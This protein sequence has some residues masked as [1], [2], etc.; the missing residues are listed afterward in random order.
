MIRI[1][2]GSVL[3]LFA[4]TSAANEY[5]EAPD[6]NRGIRD[7]IADLSGLDPAVRARAACDLRERGDDAAEAIQPLTAML[8]DAAP[9]E[10]MVCNRSWWRGSANDLTSP[11]EQ[12]AAALVAIGSRA[13]DPVLS[14]L[15][16][17]GLGGAAE[18]RLGAGGI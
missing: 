15:Q 10:A 12:A 7:L 1:I 13:F 14:T 3:A 16:S 4:L 5:P 9:V 8:G 18:R 2:V 11:G 6:Q 17:T